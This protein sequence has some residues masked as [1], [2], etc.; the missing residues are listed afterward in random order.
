MDA[1]HDMVSLAAEPEGRPAPLLR[2]GLATLEQ[3]ER[4]DDALKIYEQAVAN[5]VG[6]AETR[7]RLESLKTR[8][9][10]CL[11]R[12]RVSLAWSP[13]KPIEAAL[14]SRE[15]AFEVITRTTCRK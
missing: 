8:S 3:V 10:A 15:P 9:M 13:A 5:S 12:L 2:Q 7:H 14:I 6:D 11:P 4:C 1:I